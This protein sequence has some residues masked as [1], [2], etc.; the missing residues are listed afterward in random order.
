MTDHGEEYEQVRGRYGLHLA[1]GAT[2]GMSARKGWQATNDRGS[3][4]GSPNHFGAA[5][6]FSLRL[7]VLGLL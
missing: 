7:S 2:K 1:V 5:S 3:F 6:V 4:E